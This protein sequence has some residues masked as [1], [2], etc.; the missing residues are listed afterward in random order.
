M[1][2]RFEA[3]VCPEPTTGCWL[4]CASTDRRGYGKFGIA[5][6]TYVATR[7]AWRLYRGEIAAGLMVL[8][9]CD[10]PQCVNP[11]H[12]FLGTRVDNMRDMVVKGRSCHGAR[13]R[14]AKLSD[15]DVAAARALVVDGFTQRAVAA[16]FNVSEGC[17]SQIVNG[18][19][20]ATQKYAPPL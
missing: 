20:Y 18:K 11:V 3:K 17:M 1:L 8:H 4:W 14:S 15:R 6:R 7:V 9:H 13:H 19:T 5:G 2:D 10:T 12:L 16:Y